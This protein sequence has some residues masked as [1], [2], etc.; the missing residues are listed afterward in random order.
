[1]KSHKRSF[2]FSGN[3][4]LN[5]SSDEITLE[6]GWGTHHI[7]NPIGIKYGAR[8]MEFYHLRLGYKYLIKILT[9]EG[10]IISI[11]FKSFFGFDRTRTFELYSSVIDALWKSHFIQEYDKLVE[12]FN[13]GE[14]ISFENKYVLMDE[15]M[16]VTS[17][18]K[19][20]KFSDMKLIETSEYFRVSSLSN[21]KLYTN[22]YYL[23]TWNA[24]MLYSILE[25][26]IKNADA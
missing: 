19:T 16:K 26:I 2:E 13:N 18:K 20:I 9:E 1:M 3:N 10:K 6:N 24:V 25:S 11:P 14:D 23:K 21:S 15:G 5:I 22:V 8:V 7:K 12:R 4:K 17:G